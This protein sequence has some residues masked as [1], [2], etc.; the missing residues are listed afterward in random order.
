MKIEALMEMYTAVGDRESVKRNNEELETLERECASAQ[1]RVEE[2]LDSRAHEESS[3]SG[4]WL[5]GKSI[6]RSMNK[7][8]EDQIKQ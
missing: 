8:K 1:N 5:S 7:V 4:S 2:Y 6:R 3:T